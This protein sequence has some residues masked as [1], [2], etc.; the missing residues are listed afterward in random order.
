MSLVLG[1]RVKRL[2]WDRRHWKKGGGGEGGG[3]IRKGQKANTWAKERDLG[4]E[5]RP[6]LCFTLVFFLSQLFHIVEGKVLMSSKS[7]RKDRPHLPKGKSSVPITSALPCPSPC[8]V[9]RG[10]EEVG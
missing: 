3:E 9:G 4:C 10:K 2:V 7:M 5:A 6:V 8:P 1:V